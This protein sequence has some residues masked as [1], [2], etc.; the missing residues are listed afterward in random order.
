MRS[1]NEKRRSKSRNTRKKL[2]RRRYLSRNRNSLNR[3][4]KTIKN[5]KEQMILSWIKLQRRGRSKRNKSKLLILD[6]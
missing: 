5:R 4:L 1:S 3:N 2:T 6:L